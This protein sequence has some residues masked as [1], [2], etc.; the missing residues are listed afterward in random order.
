MPTLN[1][2]CRSFAIPPFSLHKHFL[3]SPSSTKG[4]AVSQLGYYVRLG[5]Y[6]SPANQQRVNPVTL[7][8]PIVIAIQA[9]GQACWDLGHFPDKFKRAR[10]VAVRKPGKSSYEDPGA[11]RPFTL[12]STIGK[13]IETITAKR[14]ST[15]AEAHILLP[16]SQ[17]GNRPKRST[18]TALELLTIQIH[19]VLGSKPFIIGHRWC[20]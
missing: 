18:D 20:V 8:A 4:S 15:L 12:L 1:V 19:T 6:D 16:K 10:T 14:L 3:G 2:L 7:G 9:I 13:V 11:W 17:M 5:P